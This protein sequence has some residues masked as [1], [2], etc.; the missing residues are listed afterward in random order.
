MGECAAAA[1]AGALSLD[2]SAAVICQRSRL[3]KRASGRGLMAIA[4]LSLEEAESL[5][6]RS[7]GRIS[8]AANNSPS[9][10]VFSGDRD[11]IEELLAELQ[12]QEVFCRRINVDVASHCAHMDPFR[13]ELK[14]H[15]RGLEPKKASVPMYST[16]TGSVEDGLAL[17]AEYWSRNLR[18]PVLFSAAIQRLLAD[19]INTFIEMNAHPVLLHAV[20]AGN[21]TCGGGCH[22]RGLS[23]PGE[24]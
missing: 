23:S 24:E 19:G 17:D 2:R 7:H 15:L 18:Q 16:T 8:I 11:A 20:Q 9:S 21:Q 6:R 3:M 13:P 12:R 14:E 1:V 4:E 5:A 22:S 10:T